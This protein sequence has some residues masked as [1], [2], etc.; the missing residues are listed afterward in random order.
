MA[1]VHWLDSALD[2]VHKLKGDNRIYVAKQNLG[3]DGK[4]RIQRFG[5]PDRSNYDGIHMRGRLA[6][7]HMT[8]TFVNM[9]TDIYPHLKPTFS[10]NT[11][12]LTGT[13]NSEN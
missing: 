13:V 7:Q 6:T 8:M 12:Q 3:C 4:L 5:Q 10:T 9:L 1:T 11:E 2:D